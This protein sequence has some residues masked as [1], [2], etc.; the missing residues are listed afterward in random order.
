MKSNKKIT[1]DSQW[2]FTHNLFHMPLY[3]M[4]CTSH[5]NGIFMF[6]PICRQ[7][8]MFFHK[9]SFIN[10]WQ[11][12]TQW[13]VRVR[14]L[15]KQNSEVHILTVLALSSSWSCESHV[16]LSSLTSI[17]C[18]MIN[19]VTEK[20]CLS[21]NGQ[22]KIF[23]LKKNQIFLRL[24]KAATSCETHWPIF[25]CWTFCVWDHVCLL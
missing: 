24:S 2:M 12:E 11:F 1:L 16:F 14:P 19:A 9:T 4:A 8:Q 22:L 10:A 23:I 25:V 18:C 6:Y 15:S 20:Y 17:L 5:F 13:K 3:L 21:A 7:A